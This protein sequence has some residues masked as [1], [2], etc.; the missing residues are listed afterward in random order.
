[1][2]A[3][4]PATAA[5]ASSMRVPHLPQNLKPG[6]ISVPHDGHVLPALIWSS[7]GSSPSSAAPNSSPLGPSSQGEQ[8]WRRAPMSRSRR[9]KRPSSRTIAKRGPPEDMAGHPQFESRHRAPGRGKATQENRGGVVKRPARS[10]T[11][12]GLGLPG[13]ALSSNP[14]DRPRAAWLQAS[15]RQRPFRVNGSQRPGL[16]ATG[17]NLEPFPFDASVRFQERLDAAMSPCRS[18]VDL[19]HVGEGNRIAYT[20]QKKR[21]SFNNRSPTTDAY[22]TAFDRQQPARPTYRQERGTIPSSVMRSRKY[23]RTDC[24]TEGGM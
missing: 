8:S 22:R 6:G 2:A 11:G 16:R 21:I 17:T 24:L 12:V 20:R 18:T 19:T 5:G 14:F 13:A 7:S 10:G 23:A 9:K 3:P 4:P 15:T 1:L